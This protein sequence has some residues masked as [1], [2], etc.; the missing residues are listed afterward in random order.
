MKI[1][2]VLAIAGAVV[3]AGA[4]C[5]PG[6]V[7]VATIGPTSLATGLVGHWTFD[8]GAGSTARDSSGNGRDGTISGT[9]SGPGWG[10][11]EGRF[12]GAVQLTG[13][14]Q[15]IVGGGFGFPQPTANYSVSA[16]LR[17]SSGDIEPPVAPVLSTEIP[18][19]V[20]PPGGWSLNLDL[21]P[22]G[23]SELG[24]YHFTYWFAQ[25]PTDVVYVECVCV[26][27][28]A[29]VHLAAVVDA[30]KDT[31]TFYVDGRARQQVPITRGIWPAP[32]SLF[33]GRAPQ[34]GPGPL[35]QL[36]GAL[37]DVAIYSR[38]L[39]PEEVSL[40]AAAPAPDPQ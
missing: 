12:A 34:P 25:G 13:V 36:A 20:G 24:N 40:L 35:W 11:T 23:S 21:P 16:W 19:G 15:V 6:P 4:A 31:L 18:W 37:D 30:E 14:D 2:H 32:G 7:D 38:A 5:T 17:V 1:V 33:M 3:A 10:W 9:I 27:F 26:V 39:V 8:D 29:W 28:E 22:P